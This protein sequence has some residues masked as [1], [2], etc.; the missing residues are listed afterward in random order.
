MPSSIPGT[1]L[2]LVLASLVVGLVLSFLGINPIEAVH[3]FGGFAASV[4]RLAVS[5]LE[6]GAPYIVSGA[7]IVVPIWAI[8]FLLR[9]L[10]GRR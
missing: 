10:R 2:R 1:I 4:F 7:V 5:W 8:V 9:R 3:D 6:R